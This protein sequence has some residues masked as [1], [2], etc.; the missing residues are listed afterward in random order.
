MNDSFPFRVTARSNYKF[1][2]ALLACEGHAMRAP[3]I[4]ASLAALALLAAIVVLL[5]VAY[6]TNDDVCLTMIVSGRGFCP[7][8]DEHM[9]FSNILLGH[10]LKWLYQFRPLFPWYGSYLLLTHYLSQ[11][12]V[13]YCAI[14]INREATPDI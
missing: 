8:P 3:L 7:R 6:E 1:R 5:R 9:L 2:A 10:V 14:T 12:A 11:V 13:L 4:F